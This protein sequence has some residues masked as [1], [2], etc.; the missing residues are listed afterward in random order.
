MKL[1]VLYFR[2]LRGEKVNFYLETEKVM[3]LGAAADMLWTYKLYVLKDRDL[4]LIKKTAKKYEF[5]EISD[6]E[7]EQAI[8]G[9]F[10]EKSS[11]RAEGLRAVMQEKIMD[12]A[13]DI[14]SYKRR[15]LLS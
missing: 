2:G 15:I 9:W 13:R 1:H 6:L 10:E 8:D 14:F 11:F 5:R 3:V 7:L 4:S 12:Y